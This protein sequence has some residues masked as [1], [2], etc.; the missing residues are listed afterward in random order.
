MYMTVARVYRAVFGGD[1]Q[2]NTNLIICACVLANIRL[3]PYRDTGTVIL[4]RR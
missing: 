1:F 4:I 3:D 2:L